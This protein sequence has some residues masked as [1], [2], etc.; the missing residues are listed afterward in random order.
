MKLHKTFQ[1]QREQARISFETL[2]DRICAELETLERDASEDI[3][4]HSPKTFHFQAQARANGGAGRGGFLENGRL[5]EKAGV[6]TS[7]TH[8]H[9]PPEIAL[10]MP[11]ASKRNVGLSALSW[12]IVETRVFQPHRPPTVGVR[13]QTDG[14]PNSQ[15]LKR[16]EWCSSRSQ[17]FA[18]WVV[19]AL[20]RQLHHSATAK[21]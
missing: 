2:R 13:L 17:T 1:S 7:T 12:Q 3:F 16:D 10:S 8:G 11:G 9:F 20:D 18:D 5:F 14:G 15:C 6:H 4:G 21:Q 19:V